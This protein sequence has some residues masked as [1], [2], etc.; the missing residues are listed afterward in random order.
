[1]V[2]DRSQSKLQED[3]VSLYLR[4]NGFFVSGFIVH[5]PVH[6]KNQT[7][8]DALALRLPFSSEPE[9]EIGP[10]LLLDLSTKYTDLALCE[11]KSK[12][13]ALQFNQA[14]TSQ[15]S[16]AATVLRWSGLFE[17]SEVIDLSN[18]VRTALSQNGQ[19]KCVAP[20]VSGPRGVRIRGLLFSPE[21]DSRRANQPWF[22]TGPEIMCYVW[23]CL[24]P[25]APRQSC[26]TTY[27]FQ[28][29]GNHESIVRY[30][31]SRGSESPGKMSDLYAFNK[32]SGL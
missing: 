14:L 26:A 19:I 7:E 17:D 20:T 5:S 3:L 18:A 4:L 22:V 29:W 9:R 23:R 1:M 32:K 25:Q 30:F 16:V 21:R 2:V 15:P 24:C 28:L 11:V 12:G 27:D 10:D 13:Q 31:K 6:G 8:L